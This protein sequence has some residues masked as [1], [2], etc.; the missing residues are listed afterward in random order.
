MAIRIKELQ[1]EVLIKGRLNDVLFARL[2]DAE[3]RVLEI[4]RTA[5]GEKISKEEHCRETPQDGIKRIDTILYAKLIQQARANLEM[6][7][8]KTHNLAAY[9]YGYLT[10][11]QELANVPRTMRYPEEQRAEEQMV[12]TRAQFQAAVDQRVEEVKEDLTRSHKEECAYIQEGFVVEAIHASMIS[13][14]SR[15]EWT[16]VDYASVPHGWDRRRLADRVANF[17]FKNRLHLNPQSIWYNAHSLNH[18]GR[19]SLA[20]HPLGIRE[21]QGGYFFRLQERFTLLKKAGVKH[22]LRN[23]AFDGDDYDRQPSGTWEEQI[24]LIQG[25]W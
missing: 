7:E 1:V 15:E 9:N 14:A 3:V 8:Q 24:Q 4:Q 5:Q 10:R 22:V 21:L 17:V 19:L 12:Y 11:D 18:N 23:S 20:K 13:G 2:K 6:E 25:H 16:T